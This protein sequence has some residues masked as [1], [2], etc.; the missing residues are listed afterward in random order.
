[1]HPVIGCPQASERGEAMRSR[2][3]ALVLTALGGLA[4]LAFL[5]PP[6]SAQFPQFQVSHFGAD[7]D[8]DTG[9]QLTELAFNTRTNQYLV[10][11]IAGSRATND[12]ENHWNVFA[13]RVDVGGA[14]VGGPVQINATPTSFLGDF[15]PPS[16]AYS[17]KT[18]QW[19]VVWGEGTT[20]DCDDAIYSQLVDANGNLVAPTSQRISTTGYTDTETDPIVYN[21][22]ADEF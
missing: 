8:P 6:A 22:T 17:R 11:Y 13:Q 15:E 18:N 9:A 19:M 14:T 7:D 20:T 3:K 21:S 12:D 10:V 16:V 2:I 1:M 4:L 5:A